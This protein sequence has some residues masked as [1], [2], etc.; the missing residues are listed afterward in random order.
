MVRGVKLRR[1][2]SFKL[3]DYVSGT[4]HFDDIGYIFY[5]HHL[6]APR[7]GKHPLNRFRKKMVSM[8]ANFAKYGY[9]KR[10]IIKFN[11]FLK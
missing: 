2:D 3:H 6:K 4:S 11:R 1:S 10:K 5:V 9:E 7:D 8:W